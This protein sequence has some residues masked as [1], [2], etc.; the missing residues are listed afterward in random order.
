MAVEDDGVCP[1]ETI[2]LE[3][4][5][6]FQVSVHHDG[7]A[8]ADGTAWQQ[9]ADRSGACPNCPQIITDNDDVAVGIESCDTCGTLAGLSAAWDEAWRRRYR[10]ITAE[11]ADRRNRIIVRTETR[12]E[13]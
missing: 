5:I 10:Q 1:A 13:G 9:L 2:S 8:G 7:S 3:Q 12:F 4:A 6:P 11:P